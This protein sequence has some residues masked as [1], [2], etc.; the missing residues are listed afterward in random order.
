L[1]PKKIWPE[2]LGEVSPSKV[3]TKTGNLDEISEPTGS[4]YKKC[5]QKGF[6]L[7]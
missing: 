4:K 7:F 5:A 6:F 1:C 2:L 3:C